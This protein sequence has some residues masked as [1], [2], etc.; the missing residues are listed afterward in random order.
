MAISISRQPLLS[1]KKISNW[2]WNVNSFNHVHN[3]KILPKRW[4]L[5]RIYFI[6]GFWETATIFN[7]NK[8]LE[9]FLILF[10]SLTMRFVSFPRADLVWKRKFGQVQI[11]WK[12]HKLEIPQINAHTWGK[13]AP[14]RV[15]GEGGRRGG[16]IRLV[17]N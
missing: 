17:Y 1:E 8:V 7:K 10:R 15:R 5:L 14:C 11:N 16:W 4:K 12:S 9:P 2:R 3:K 6:L 13:F